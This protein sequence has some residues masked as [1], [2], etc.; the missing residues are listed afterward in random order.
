MKFVFKNKI[1][2]TFPL[3]LGSTAWIGATEEIILESGQIFIKQHIGH[4]LPSIFQV[5]LSD[6]CRG[7]MITHTD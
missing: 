6:F 2:L 7:C 5:R 1:F 3:F 4:I